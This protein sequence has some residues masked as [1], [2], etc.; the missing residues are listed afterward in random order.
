MS[1]H[2]EARS[3]DASADK[4]S[5][6]TKKSQATSNES[7]IGNAREAM[8]M[9]A[10]AAASDDNDE[11]CTSLAALKR[12]HLNEALASH[13][14]TQRLQRMC[15]YLKVSQTV[16]QSDNCCYC[17]WHTNG[18]VQSRNAEQ[19]QKQKIISLNRQFCNIQ[20]FCGIRCGGV[21]ITLKE[22]LHS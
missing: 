5:L 20:Y 14:E 3:I 2:Y 15:R 10:A 9:A 11:E 12:A 16:S 22:V 8:R 4:T 19:K 17:C 21:K 18:R 1:H 13:E 6:G 7:F